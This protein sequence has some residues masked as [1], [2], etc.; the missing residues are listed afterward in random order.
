MSNGSH[1]HEA[2]ERNGNV[3]VLES[4]VDTMEHA[5]RSL[6]NVVESQRDI[7]QNLAKA[8]SLLQQSEQNAVE[9]RIDIT[10]KIDSL[11][12]KVVALDNNQS[13]L[14]GGWWAL[15]VIGSALVGLATVAGVLGTLLA[16]KP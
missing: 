16:K 4:R 11:D 12:V 14:R 13:M 6:V 3:A 5:V 8:I 1:H 10:R 9:S 7:V 2:T 15:A